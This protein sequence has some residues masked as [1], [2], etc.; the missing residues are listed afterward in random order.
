MIITQGFINGGLTLQGY[1]SIQPT[2]NIVRYTN[3]I[4]VSDSI[5]DG[6]RRL[7]VAIAVDA[8]P[9]KNTI[10]LGGHVLHLWGMSNRR[11]YT[12]PVY[13]EESPTVFDGS[14]A[15]INGRVCDISKSGNRGAYCLTVSDTARGITPARYVKLDSVPIAVNAYGDAILAVPSGRT[16]QKEDAVF[17]MGQTMRLVLVDNQWRVVVNL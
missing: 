16:I 4:N 17:W 3:N 14:S 15:T 13:I 6:K 10:Q 9:T 2:T 8:F 12:I 5:V 11:F 1:G 7:N